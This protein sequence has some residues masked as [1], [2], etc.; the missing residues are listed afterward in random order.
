M[1]HLI[2]ILALL[3]CASCG[4]GKLSLEEQEKCKEALNA[5]QIYINVKNFYVDEY[6]FL[7]CIVSPTE[8]EESPDNSAEYTYYMS[9]KPPLR[10]V[11]ILNLD[12]VIIGEFSK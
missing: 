11:K 12:G 1:K 8:L 5:D 9:C 4:N 10:G 2:L 7:C 6:G 3:L